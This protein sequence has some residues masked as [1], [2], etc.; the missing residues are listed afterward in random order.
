MNK[1][2]Y[3]LVRKN[4]SLDGTHTSLK[5]SQAE[6]FELIIKEAIKRDT[7]RNQLAYILATTWY[8]T[9]YTMQPIEEYGKGH[10]KKYGRKDRK[11]GK[12]YY[13]RSYPQVT[14]KFNYQKLKDYYGVD[15]VSYPEKVMEPK[16]A[17]PLLFDGMEN[18]W[19][20]GKKLSNYIT[21]RK[22]NFVGAR[23]IINGTDKAQ[24]FANFAKV[25]DEALKESGYG[26]TNISEKSLIKSRTI[27]G[28]AASSIAGTTVLV[29]DAIEI[30]T[31]QQPSLTSGDYAIMAF[32]VLTIVGGLTSIYARWDDAGRPSLSEM[33]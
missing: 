10:G 29:K 7:L 18:G 15:F 32:S 22:S 4:I 1:T 9:G 24:M 12:V 11:T 3:D 20:T 27:A 28:G 31:A 26:V 16:Y 13:G 33:F 17:I 23:R 6:G 30:I 2:F 19:W 5:Q 14:W 25:F 8:E 21:L